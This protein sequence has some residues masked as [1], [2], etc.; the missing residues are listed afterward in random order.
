MIKISCP[1]MNC[2]SNNNGICN[3]VELN[4]MVSERE[5]IEL[6]AGCLSYEFDQDKWMK[7]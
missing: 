4:R 5:S 6:P 3:N 1:W 7:G 2:K